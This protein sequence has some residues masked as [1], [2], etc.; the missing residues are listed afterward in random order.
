MFTFTSGNSLLEPAGLDRDMFREAVTKIDNDVKESKSLLPCLIIRRIEL[1]IN[2]PCK[3]QK[4]S[5]RLA[6]KQHLIF[7]G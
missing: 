7:L 2:Y 5:R 4:L 6:H 3:L 1:S